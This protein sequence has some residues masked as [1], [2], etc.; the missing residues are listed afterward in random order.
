MSTSHPDRRSAPL[1]LGLSATLLLAV[2][3]TPNEEQ[4]PIDVAEEMLTEAITPGTRVAGYQI[5]DRA[6][7]LYSG[8]PVEVQDLYR[9]G[10]E[11][12]GNAVEDPAQ[13]LAVPG[14]DFPLADTF[15]VARSFIEE[16]D[17][18]PTVTVWAL[19]PNLTTTDAACDGREV[20]RKALLGSEE[21][22]PVAD[23]ISVEGLTRLWGEV[24][25]TGARVQR[26]EV[27]RGGDEMSVMFTSSDPE[28][29][30][31]WS[32]GLSVVGSSLMSHPASGPEAQ[33]DLSTLTPEVFGETVGELLTTVD[34]ADVARI[35]VLPESEGAG[36]QVVLQAEDWTEL[37]Y[38][39][40]GS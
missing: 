16:C 1:L 23:P 24:E 17:G 11:G 38:T 5:T 2:A 13:P 37:A 12:A 27:D 39:R 9:V 35:V 22:P 28:R 18:E 32:R 3:C 21:L 25:A 26:V 40:I 33:L 7:T 19:A 20:T 14:R 29:L 8:R 10:A 34:Q 30:F 4:A 15:A 31:Q 36:V 6:V